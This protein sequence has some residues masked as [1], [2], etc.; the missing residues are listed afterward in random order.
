MAPVAAEDDI[1]PQT[2]LRRRYLSQR[3]VVITFAGYYFPPRGIGRICIEV[4][5]SRL[6]LL[7]P[8]VLDVANCFSKLAVGF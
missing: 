5:S 3:K 2:R 7:E 6:G 4:A 8:A 1:V